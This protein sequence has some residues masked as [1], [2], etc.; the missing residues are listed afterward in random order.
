MILF[1]FWYRWINGLDERP[2]NSL[3]MLDYKLKKLLKNLGFKKEE[4]KEKPHVNKL[5]ITEIDECLQKVREERRKNKLEIDD[6]D[7]KIVKLQKQ[8]NDLKNI[9]KEKK[10]MIGTLDQKKKFLNKQRRRIESADRSLD[11]SADSTQ[12]S[13]GSNKSF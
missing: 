9:V 7:Y 13:A 12:T 5:N 6:L 4:K 11:L 2:D 8:M 10:R 1:Q 3:T